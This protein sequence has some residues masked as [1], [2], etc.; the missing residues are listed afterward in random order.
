MEWFEEEE[1][2]RA[3][4]EMMMA[5]TDLEI[6]KRQLAM[7]SDFNLP[8]AFKMFDLDHSGEITRRQFEE[9]FNLLKLYPTSLEVE[10][11]LFRYDKDLDGRLN[12][13]E[14]KAAILPADTN[15]SDLVLRRQPYCSQM[16]FARLQFFLD[17][18][19]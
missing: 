8:D 15:Y 12:F 3:M 18:T 9:V 17:T 2:A 13:D 6:M 10:L 16:D 1:L 14:F 7:E 5:E 19:T 11:A 4:Y